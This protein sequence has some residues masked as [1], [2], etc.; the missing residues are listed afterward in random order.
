MDKG[1]SGYGGVDSLQ[2]M[3][4]SSICLKNSGIEV[5]AVYKTELNSLMSCRS[6]GCT[7]DVPLVSDSGDDALEV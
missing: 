3:E 5:R 2:E 4:F 6:S 1:E 7:Y